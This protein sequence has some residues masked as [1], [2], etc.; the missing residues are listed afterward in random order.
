[1]NYVSSRNKN[2]NTRGTKL[3]H[4]NIAATHFMRAAYREREGE[5]DTQRE[6]VH[7]RAC[8]RVLDRPKENAFGWEVGE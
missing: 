7:V 6:H 3:K 5:R 1:M 2:V 8:T 4:I